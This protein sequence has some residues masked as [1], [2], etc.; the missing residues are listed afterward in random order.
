VKLSDIIT[1]ELLDQT[2]H[3]GRELTKADIEESQALIDANRPLFQVFAKCHRN[4]GTFG[5]SSLEE[6]DGITFTV[7]TSID[8]AIR[9]AIADDKPPAS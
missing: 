5:T 7:L 1:P 8:R 3:P 9:A 2:I 4:C 6:C